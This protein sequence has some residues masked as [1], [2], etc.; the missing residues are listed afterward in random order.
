MAP[1]TI[2][3]DVLGELTESSEEPGTFL[4]T[5][6]CDGMSATLRIE[7][8]GYSVPDCLGLAR[9]AVRSFASLVESA[10]DAAVVDLLDTYNCAWRE[11]DESDGQGNWITVSNPVLDA[12]EFKSR[13]QLNSLVVMGDKLCSFLFD[14]GGMFGGHCIDV[15]AMDG[16]VFQ[17]FDVMLIG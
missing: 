8:A 4:G 7:T 6:S 9:I 17:D 12:A 15:S 10:R 11:Y 5:I 14:D 16:A 1:R 2:N 13:M 3:D